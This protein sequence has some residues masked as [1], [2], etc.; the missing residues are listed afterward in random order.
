[1]NTATVSPKVSRKQLIIA[2][3]R[4]HLKAWLLAA[5]AHGTIYYNVQS[6][7]R[8]GMNRKI[9]LSTIIVRDVTEPEDHGMYTHPELVRLWPSYGEQDLPDELTRG[10]GNFGSTLDIIARDWGFS[11]DARAFN[12]SG[13]GMDMV[14]ALVDDLAHRAGIGKLDPAGDGRTSYANRVRR[15][16]F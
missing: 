10:S 14:Y 1:M 13:T 16:A 6:V 5:E 8:S 11:F 9:S 15:E 2:A 7:S 4:A 3:G 12:V